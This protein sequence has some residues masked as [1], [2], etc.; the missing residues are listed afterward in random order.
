MERTRM[1]EGAPSSL[2]EWTRTRLEQ[3]PP[4]RL[5][6]GFS[7]GRDS[8]ALLDVLARLPEARARG[9]RAIHV[10]HGLHAEAD[11]WTE[12]CRQACAV[13]SV[14]LTVCA[15]RVRALGQGP[16]A[17]AREARME[18]FAEAITDG[19][20][21]ALAHHREDQEETVLLKLL[22]G[23]GPHGLAGMRAWRPLGA[24]SIWR[25][26][27]ELPRRE[28]DEWITAAGLTAIED[29]ANL[30]PGMTRSWLRREIL[31]RIRAHLP[32]ATASI[33]HSAHI[34]ADVRDHLDAGVAAASALIDHAHRLDANGWL[35]LPAALRG[36]FLD[37]WLRLRGHDVP[38]IP[39]RTELER[40]VREA[41]PDAVPH[42]HWPGTDVRLWRGRLY[43]MAPLPPPPADWH[44][45]WDGSPLALPL[46]TLSLQD[47]ASGSAPP[48]WPANISVRLRRGGEYLHPAGDPHG[49]ELRYIFQQADLPPWLRPFCPLVFAGDELLAVADLAVSTAGEALFDRLGARPE[50]RYDLHSDSR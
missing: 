5:A 22:R 12:L 27:L 41:A 24:G 15:V 33:L 29:P 46:G 4:G 25:P 23:A 19:E 48:N 37:H 11:R 17:A 6:V 42:L 3:C 18:A 16:E 34:F 26:W 14:D 21:L 1:T 44:R 49:R 2:P 9:L 35:A 47:R 28:I 7:G 10:N 45:P 20:I 50:W 36:L 38:T 13:R 39:Q 30:D 31:P 43:A 8:L 40:Q 32:Q